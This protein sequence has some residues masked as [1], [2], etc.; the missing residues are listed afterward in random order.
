MK[1]IAAIVCAGLW[2]AFLPSASLCAAAS[3]PA[4]FRVPAGLPDA[5]EALSPAA[6]HLD[7]WLGD[8][9]RAN[10]TNRLLHVDTEPLLAGFRKRPGSHPWIGEHVGKWMHAATLAWAYTGDPDL[11]TKLDRVAAE[12]IAC[13]EPDG[14]LG[15]YVPGKRFGLYPDADWDVWSHKYNL[16]GLLTYYQYT[17]NEAAL[18]ACRKMGD[19]LIKTFGP[20]KKSILSAGTHVGMA[21]TSA[22]EPVVLLYRFTGDE[23]YLDFA[24]Y[25]VKSWDEP[26]GP[27]IIQA[28]LTAQQVNKTANAK[29]YEMLSNLVGLC[30]LARATGD[31]K[32]LEPVLNAWNDIVARRLYLTGSASQGEHFRDDYELPN[33]AGAHVA[34]TCVTTTWIQ[35]NL[36]LLRLTGGA[37]YANELE[38]TLYNHLAAAQHPR[39]DDWCYF[40]ALEGRK[41]YD[42]GINCCHSSGPRGLALAPQAAYLKTRGDD[43]DAIAVSTFETSRATVELGGGTAVTVDQQSQFPRKGESVL[44]FKLSR[45]VRFALEVRSPAWAAPVRL[46]AQGQPAEARER[47][48][49]VTLPAREWKDGDQVNVRFSLGASVVTGTHGNAGRAALTWGPFVLAYDARINPGLPAPAGL[50]FAELGKPPFTLRPGPPLVFG[51]EV[52][53]ARQAQSMRANFVTFADAGRDGGAY[54]VWLR[55]PGAD[56]PKNESL[57][58]DGEESRSRPGNQ[59][60]SVIDG[61]RATFVV[62]FDARPAKEDWFAVSLSEPVAVARVVFTHGK[63]FH[64]GGWF[65]ASRGRPRIQ[66]QRAKGGPWETVGELAEYP[67]TTA[68]DAGGLKPGQSFTLRLTQPVQAVAVRAVGAPAGG[69]NPKQAFCSCAELQAFAD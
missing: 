46:A 11:R 26:N 64:D 24:R 44:T 57:L 3:Q 6:I 36:Q 25:L 16:M 28:L 47:D 1:R 49:W 59:N 65:D 30:E 34:E 10:A 17:G 37:R 52:R 68:T 2:L 13:Q 35:L 23:R 42:A 55:A 12:L 7:G 14:Y 32:L 38:R 66:V 9:I 51:A 56:W 19:L 5:A 20:G 39:G 58:A 48:G 45:P 41:P 53:S 69:D 27:K 18:T 40:T 62:T 15:T 29:A 50:G 67:A 63:N 33:Q 31:R 61:D 21:A 22:L 60:G 54:R 43:A 8:R 4:P